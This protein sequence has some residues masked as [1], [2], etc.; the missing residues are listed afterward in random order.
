MPAQ[1]N[2][3]VSGQIEIRWHAKNKGLVHSDA[4]GI[5]AVGYSAEML[6]RKIVG[7]REI[8]AEL[9]QPRLALRAGPIRIDH[10]ADRGQIARLEFRYSRP[11]ICYPTDDLMAG[12][13]GIGRRHYLTPFIANLVKIG[14]TDAAKKNLDLY[15]F[16]RRITALDGV[17]GKSRGCALGR[18][19]L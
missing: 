12:Y 4:V 18:E 17:R 3:A 8:R 5:A 10:A 7:K 19:G 6:I 11:D 1:S 9:L 16:R 13:A 2:G 14:V 15:V